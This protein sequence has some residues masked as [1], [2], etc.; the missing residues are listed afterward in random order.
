MPAN[1]AIV[2]KSRVGSMPAATALVGLTGVLLAAVLAGLAVG[3]NP[4]AAQP[5]EGS[6]FFAEY[7]GYDEPQ[8]VAPM[9][10]D[11]VISS[12]DG[13]IRAVPASVCL[14]YT[15]PSPRDA[16]LSRMPSSA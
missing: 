14:L 15:S 12:A 13:S 6:C 11:A 9:L 1:A 3:T 2:K 4:A 5:G 16:T 7:P 10:D 8:L